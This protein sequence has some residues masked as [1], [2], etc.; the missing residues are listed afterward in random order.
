MKNRVAKLVEI[1]K[2]EI[3]SEEVPKLQEGDVLVK[4]KAVG[5]C[6]SDMHYFLEGGLGSFKQKLPM[7]MGHEPSGDVVETNGVFEF[8]VGDRVAVEPGRACF[9]C[10]WC[11]KG[12][13][14]LCENGV[15]MGANGPGA[16]A[17]YVVVHKSQLAKIPK[18]MSYELGALMEPIGVA[19]HS[20]NLLNPPHTI[21]AAIVGSG[22]IGLSILAV[23]KNMGINQIFMIDK[24][25][26]RVAFAKKMGANK[27][28]LFE[29][30]SGSLKKATEG[31]GV[32]VVFDTGGTQDSVNLCINIVG[33]SG[34]IALVGIPTEDFLT[35][36]PHKLRTKEVRIQNVRRSNQTLNDGIEL[37]KSKST[38]EKMVTHTFPFEKI[39]DA[40]DLVGGYKDN[41]IKCMITSSL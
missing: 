31:R 21:S 25:P 12:K 37:F 10:R 9:Y 27:S 20:V 33:M 41:V 16:F 24:I 15:F 11:L 34:T 26:Y 28:F 29:D 6:G 5:I 14:N 38:I 18:T 36:N 8:K 23:L 39:Q 30:A 13:H 19:M 32:S 7:Y 22:P 1:R 2:I 3:V 40:F 17:D 4:M 35:Y